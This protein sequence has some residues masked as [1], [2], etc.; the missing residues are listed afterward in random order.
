MNALPTALEHF[1]PKP[2]AKPL[3]LL[4]PVDATERSRWGINYAR[5]CWQSGR[6]VA[7]SLLLV[8]EPIT[9]WQVL[10][11][12]TQEKVRR[13]QAERARYILEDASLP[14]QQAG[15]AVQTHYQEG[16]IP[17]EILDLA[18]QMGCDEIV[19]PVPYLRWTRLFTPDIVREV[20]RSQRS[21]PVITVN[22]A[23]V[24]EQ[25]RQN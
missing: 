11:F 21:I 13:L 8:A 1:E 9:S 4:V 12:L 6:E 18:E 2:L 14:L 15:I 20:L 7:V 17:F 24:P 16:D 25:D 19:L 3:K 23:G 10:R 22:A 5:R